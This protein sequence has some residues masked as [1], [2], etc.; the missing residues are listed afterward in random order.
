MRKVC[1]FGMN[2]KSLLDQHGSAILAV[3]GSVAFLGVAIEM[4]TKIST[5]A[6]VAIGSSRVTGS[7]DALVYQVSRYAALPSS[8]RSS[9]DP[10]LPSSE[11]LALKSCVLG[12]TTNGCNGDGKTEQPLSLYAPVLA[13]S[14]GSPSLQL[15]AGPG[16][17]TSNTAS[18]MR[19]DVS[20]RR[21]QTAYNGSAAKGC[22]FEV[23]ATFVATCPVG[24]PVPCTK[25][26][27]VKVRYEIKYN[28]AAVA[29][30]L[31]PAPMLAPVSG[32]SAS[33]S[34]ASIL[35]PSNGAVSTTITRVTLL[36][37]TTEG[38]EEQDSAEVTA[39]YAAIAGQGIADKSIARAMVRGGLTN[40]DF[41]M[42]LANT[43][44]KFNGITDLAV[45][46][47]IASV[48]AKDPV[49][50]SGIA[51][52]YKP[53]D[54]IA[55]IDSVFNAV[56]NSG[57]TNPE[58]AKI[59]AWIGFTDSAKVSDLAAVA[60]PYASDPNVYNAIIGNSG[61]HGE[62]VPT[63]AQV[64]ATQDAIAAAGITDKDNVWG[65]TVAG[66]TSATQAKALMAAGV[67]RVDI[68]V[69]VVRAG[70]TTV[71]EILAISDGAKQAIPDA[72]LN[73]GMNLTIAATP[74]TSTPGTQIV[75]IT[76]E[77]PNGTLSNPVISNLVTV[78]TK[79]QCDKSFGF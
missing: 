28:V 64:K 5:S 49:I 45:I 11:N 23:Y 33:T 41:A 67:T 27:S 73:Q 74:N 6:S 65:L 79:S 15:L 43:T 4:S 50:G 21:C 51:A 76:S 68:A 26:Q 22:P 38:T 3:L 61:Y 31:I 17:S 44:V 42:D 58:V 59:A 40:T 48:M 34:I 70:S 18:P 8:F 52:G 66:V 36:G 30:S 32:M 72:G 7:R 14:G 71:S 47:K 55:D 37:T 69:D 25:A 19:Y 46:E 56:K 63:A 20:G 57:V 24:T 1:G 35:S 13:T 53:L 60:A 9:I 29:K 2:Q 12:T 75:Q 77:D 16:P 54:S 78:C 62:I 39:V 10:T